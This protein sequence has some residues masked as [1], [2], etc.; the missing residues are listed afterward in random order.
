MTQ[1]AP[2]VASGND[3][4]DYAAL[5]RAAQDAVAP[6]LATLYASPG[7]VDLLEAF[8]HLGRAADYL[9]Y[10]MVG[11]RD[12]ALGELAAA[13]E[14]LREVADNAGPDAMPLS[15]IA[16]GMEE[17]SAR[18]ETWDTIHAG[19][20][21]QAALALEMRDDDFVLLE[22]G[23]ESQRF[24]TAAE[25][26]AALEGRE[27]ADTTGGKPFNVFLAPEG[28]ESGD[29]RLLELGTT[30]W[31]DPP[32]ALMMQDTSSHGPGDPNA[33]W[34]AGSIDEV[35]RDPGDST[36]I[37]GR[38]KL[39]PGSDGDRAEAQ[40]RAGLRGVSLDGIG[41]MSVPPVKQ[42]VAVNQD[43]DPVRALVRYGDTRIMGATV[44]PHPAFEP[45]CIWFDDE[46]VPERVSSTHGQMIALDAQP[47]VIDTA[48]V[49]EALVASAGGPLNPPKAWFYVDEPDRYQPLEVRA[50][51][52]I[53]GHLGKEGTCHIGDAGACTTIPRSSTGYRYFHRTTAETAE[54]AKVACGWLTMGTTHMRNLSAGQKAT[55]D[56]YDHTGTQV[57]KLRVMD[58]KHGPWACGAIAP[59]L[60]EE[61]VWKLQGPEVSGDWRTVDGHYRELVAVLSVPVPGFLTQRPE[62]LVASGQ[63]VAQIGTLPCDDGCDGSS[64]LVAAGAAP[65]FKGGDHSKLKPGEKCPK[66]G[67]VMPMAAS[68]SSDRLL[69]RLEIAERQLALLRP[70]ISA[71]MRDRLDAEFPEELAAHLAAQ[72]AQD[73]HAGDALERYR[74]KMRVPS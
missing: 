74:E 46:P 30:T 35:L 55:L 39:V 6:V 17:A 32:L 21:P 19:A 31:R 67:K 43:G 49:M 64:A 72:R 52:F 10:G 47:A 8:D 15:A 1:I 7:G 4:D 36:R 34:F 22:N 50:D 48:P 63:I 61:Q 42:I 9:H 73:R 44:V 38:G 70:Q 54:G 71:A 69:A 23:V 41:G 28:F 65:C 37:I 5:I 12:K 33:A 18:I 20:D 45:C 56:H 58:G 53:S 25:A 51:G 62:A 11:A 68:S 57:A 24:A 59:G 26:L 66:C 2:N 3:R 27:M 13:V 40:I 16:S 29:G 14:L 60:T